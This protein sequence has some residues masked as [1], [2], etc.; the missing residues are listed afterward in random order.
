[1]SG[2]RVELGLNEVV[3]VCTEGT[4]SSGCVSVGEALDESRLGQS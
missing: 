2:V 3:S 4:M 1:M